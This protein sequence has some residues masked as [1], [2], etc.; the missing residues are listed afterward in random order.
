MQ[1]ATTVP[2]PAVQLHG[3]AIDLGR[4]SPTLTK[5]WQPVLPVIKLGSNFLSGE[6]L[7]WL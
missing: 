3:I 4:N 5:D 2:R 6:V 1:R 7:N